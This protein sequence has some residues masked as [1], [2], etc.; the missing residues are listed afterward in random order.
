MNLL[1]LIVLAIGLAMDAFAVS[2][3]K[4]LE[5]K[6]INYNKCNIISTYFSVFQM[7]MPVIGYILGNIF[8]DFMYKIDHWIAFFLLLIIGINMIKESLNKDNKT[9]NDL[10]DFKTLF[11]LA[12]ATSID[13]LAVGITLSVLKVNL[14]TAIAL[15][16][17]ITYILS[18]IGVIIGN[19]IG[20][21]LSTLAELFGGVILITIGIKILIE[22]LN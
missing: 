6:N 21:K 20:N 13:A 15:I 11:P 19:K 9:E 2:V 4:G 17:I 18:I 16:G 1:E 22:H 12:V 10:I 8:K 5:V 7:A 3:C 14:F